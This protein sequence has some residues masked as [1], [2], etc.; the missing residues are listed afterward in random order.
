MRPSQVELKPVPLPFFVSLTLF[1]TLLGTLWL[2]I[3]PQV[4]LALAKSS[5]L[6]VF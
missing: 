2:G 6:I 1:L 5:F 4:F 3:F